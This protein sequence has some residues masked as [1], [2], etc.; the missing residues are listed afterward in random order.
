M[1]KIEQSAKNGK[2]EKIYICAMED[3]KKIEK[4]ENVMQRGLMILGVACS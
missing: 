1:K 3:G 2:R 4:A